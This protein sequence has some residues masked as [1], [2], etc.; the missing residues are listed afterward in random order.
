MIPSGPPVSVKVMTRNLYLGADLIPV[1]AAMTVEEIPAKVALLWKTMLASD[2]P[3][4]AKLLAD[5]I[6]AAQPDLV[7]L[8]EAVVFYKQTPGDF[9]FAAPAVNA[10]DVQFD[11]V[12]L[13]LTELQARGTEYVAAVVSKN[14]D[15]ELPAA[16]DVQPFDVRMTDRDAILVRKG[17]RGGDL[18][19]GGDALPVAPRLPHPL[20]EHHRGRRSIWCAGWC[21]SRPP[22]RGRASPSPTPTSRWGAAATTRWRAPTWRRCRRCRRAIC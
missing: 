1:V 10:T 21:G 16:D 14:T 9:S 19:P 13:L 22:S 3:G 20:R 18:E 6:A 11:F 15:V 2:L 4:R 5:E 8:Q 12:Q 7:G 17:A